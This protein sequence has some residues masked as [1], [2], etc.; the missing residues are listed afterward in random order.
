MLTEYFI[1]EAKVPRN[2]PFTFKEDGF[3]RVLKKEISEAIKTVPKQ[4][5]D[6]SKNITDLLFISYI[7]LSL[8]AV[9]STS[10]ALGTAAGLMLCLVSIAAHNF[11]HQKDNFRMYYFDFTMMQSK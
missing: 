10:Y 3:Y 7:A 2:C 1:R 9:Y 4:P 5:V 8:L 6:R 11:F